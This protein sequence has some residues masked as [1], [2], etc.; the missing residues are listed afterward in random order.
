MKRSA[1]CWQASALDVMGY[2]KEA[3]FK[4]QYA[5]SCAM[6]DF[7][8]LAIDADAAGCNIFSHISEGRAAVR[9]SSSA[10]WKVRYLL[11]V[12][13]KRSRFD[14]GAGAVKQRCI[15]RLRAILAALIILNGPGGVGMSEEAREADG[16]VRHG[17]R[18]IM[19][20]PSTQ[21]TASARAFP[22]LSNRLHAR[23]DIVWILRRRFWA[24][25]SCGSGPKAR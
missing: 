25:P 20:A 4:C 23:S 8:D 7:P 17:N 9:H 24:I 22:R 11:G 12:Y 13:R 18:G 2:L 19:S 6:L 21:A 5:L 14:F 15:G 10:S 16:R 1:R 3:A